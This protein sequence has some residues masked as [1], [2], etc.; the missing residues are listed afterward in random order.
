MRV[1]IGIPNAVP[2]AEGASL[3]PWARRAEAAGFS[4]LGV[5]DRMRYDSFEPM[6]T[7]G[8]AAGATSSIRLVTMVVIGPLRPTAVLAKQAAT[9][10]AMSGGRLVLGLAVGARIEDYQ[11]LQIPSGGRGDRLAD[12]L[13]EL[14][15][16]FESD[17]FGPL[18]TPAGP[19]LLVGGLSDVTFERIARHADG[20]VH[21]GGPA[22]T[23]ARAVEKTRK[24]WSD[25]RRVGRPSLWAQ[26]YFALGG[27][28]A[29]QAG[30]DYLIDYY[31]FTGPF[32]RNI[33]NALLDTPQS[34]VHYLRGYA[35]AGCDELVL[36]PAV[37]G[38]DLTDG[39]P[40]EK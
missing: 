6:A 22:R 16:Y 26:A 20:Y 33:A 18:A 40:Q 39:P 9:L 37:A 4:S 38:I 31:S 13:V 15:N 19:P 34:V 10:D 14:R 23:F 11:A 8:A 3:V 36:L 2:G 1:G 5:V 27:E 28:Q 25:H 21:G 24:A 35:E 7:L 29:S 32:A 30:K 17:N 12:Q